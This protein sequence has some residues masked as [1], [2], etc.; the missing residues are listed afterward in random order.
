MRLVSVGEGGG[1][2]GYN[3]KCTVYMSLS[4]SVVRTEPRF[5]RFI[6]LR[7]RNHSFFRDN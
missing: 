4:S 2:G 3:S 6:T 1:G 5:A 7:E